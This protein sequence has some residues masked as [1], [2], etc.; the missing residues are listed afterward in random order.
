MP[1]IGH[2]QTCFLEAPLV[3]SNPYHS[4]VYQP[5]ESTAL[6][7]PYMLHIA[8]ESP[9]DPSAAPNALQANCQLAEDYMFSSEPIPSKVHHAIPSFSQ[10]T[11]ATQSSIV[12]RLQCEMCGKRFDRSTRVEKCRNRH[13]GIKPFECRGR[14]GAF[15]W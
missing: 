11:P 9:S 5:S 7:L 13:Q 3:F 10:V 14:C 4:I 1:P 8:D 6:Y 15:G 12:H 2:S